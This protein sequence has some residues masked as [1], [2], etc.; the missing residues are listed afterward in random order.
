MAIGGTATRHVPDTRPRDWTRKA[1]LLVEAAAEIHMVIFFNKTADL[2]RQVGRVTIEQT[3]MKL[4]KNHERKTKEGLTA[5]NVGEIVKIIRMP[6]AEQRAEK[7][8]GL[9]F[10][11]EK[12]VKHSQDPHQA[13]IIENQPPGCLECQ[14]GIARNPETRWR[15]G[16]VREY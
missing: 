11:C 7:A 12:N 6:R 3:D 5:E 10:E 13:N 9:R 1:L 2:V 4:V 14:D 15:R 16:G 8:W